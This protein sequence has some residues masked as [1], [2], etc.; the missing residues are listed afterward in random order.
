MSAEPVLAHE[1]KHGNAMSG[2]LEEICCIHCGKFIANMGAAC[3]ARKLPESESKSTMRGH[4]LGFD[5]ESLDHW[6][7]AEPVCPFCGHEEADVWELELIDDD[8]NEHECASCGRSYFITVYQP[9]PVYTT[10]TLKEPENG[11]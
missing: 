6:H 4:G 11:N 5:H 9:D 3:P 1:L 7:N 8:A 10:Y 2:R